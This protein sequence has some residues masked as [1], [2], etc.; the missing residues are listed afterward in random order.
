MSDGGDAGEQVLE[1]ANEQAIDA[2]DTRG[3]RRMRGSVVQRRPHVGDPGGGVLISIAPFEPAVVIQLE[4]IVR[5]DQPRQDERAVEIDD[6]I[7][8]VRRAR[9][10]P[11][12]GRQNGSTT[13]YRSR[14]RHDR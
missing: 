8:V 10:G 7:A 11:G 1:P 14:S 4:V 3:S 5:V 6:D 2:A 12:R 9:R 13:P